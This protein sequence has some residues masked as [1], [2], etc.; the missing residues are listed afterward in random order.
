MLSDIAHLF[1]FFETLFFIVL[2]LLSVGPKKGKK[3]SQVHLNVTQKSEVTEK[4]ECG[5]SV[6]AMYT[7]GIRKTK[8]PVS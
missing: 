7:Y 8:L 1:F 6:A 5:V 2:N 4:L 3:K